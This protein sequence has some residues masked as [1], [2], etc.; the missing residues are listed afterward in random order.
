MES[1]LLI[2]GGK[3]SLLVPP[4]NKIKGENERGVP[5]EENA[6]QHIV[7]AKSFKSIFGTHLHF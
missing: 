3:K 6:S 1:L 2:T 5:L 7:C 4:V